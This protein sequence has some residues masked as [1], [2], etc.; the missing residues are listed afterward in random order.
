MAPADD[1]IA[2]AGQRQPVAALFAV[3]SLV[4]IDN[5]LVAA[6]ELVGRRAFIDIGRGEKEPA[7]NAALLVHGGMQLVAE[8]IFALLLG[9]G[10]LG[11]VFAPNELAGGLA[12][13]TGRQQ[14]F[15]SLGS[16]KRSRN[17]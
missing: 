17:Q 15:G 5:L 1:A 10:G 12:V 11:V 2:D 9:P 14:L 16:V 6:D 3:I 13:R 8:V 7:D 4:G